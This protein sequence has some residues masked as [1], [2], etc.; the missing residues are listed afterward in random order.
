MIR[1]D[2]SREGHQI[3]CITSDKIPT[4]LEKLYNK[5]GK[6]RMRKINDWTGPKYYRTF[7]VS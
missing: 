5:N 7:I 2:V 3:S 1:P 4:S 6:E